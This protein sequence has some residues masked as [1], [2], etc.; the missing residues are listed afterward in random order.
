L[1]CALGSVV[2][3]LGCASRPGPAQAAHLY[4]AGVEHDASEAAYDLVH[5]DLRSRLS[6]EEFKRRLHDDRERA[7]QDAVRVDQAT[8]DPEAL[9]IFAECAGGVLLQYEDGD[10]KL[11]ASSLDFYSQASPLEAI[12]SFV[13]AFRAGRFDVLARLVGR[14]LSGLSAGPRPKTD[15]QIATEAELADTV[16]SIALALEDPQIEVLGPRA[17]MSYGAA[18]SIE[19]VLHGPEWKI[20]DYDP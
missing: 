15:P 8:Q 18:K 4:V 2:A 1:V 10:W 11:A 13:R 5:E 3:T 12:R 14:D 6:L 7:L 19:L 16:D 20:E 17:R 9:W